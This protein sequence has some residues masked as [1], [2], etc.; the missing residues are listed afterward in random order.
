MAISI[1]YPSGNIFI[2]KG[3]TTLLG[4]DAQGNQIREFDVLQFWRDLRA[5]EDSEEGRAFPR[6]LDS[7]PPQTAFDLARSVLITVYYFVEFDDASGTD[8]YKVRLALANNNIADQQILNLVQLQSSNSAGLAQSSLIDQTNQR[9][10]ELWQNEGLEVGNPLTVTPASR[11]TQD[12]TIDLDL[13][14]DG[15]SS[16]TVTRQ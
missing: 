11:S 15:I 16:T 1:D 13:T 3:D 2:P 8:A 4:L 7:D 9:T 6:I 5:A 14:G 10:T 12:N